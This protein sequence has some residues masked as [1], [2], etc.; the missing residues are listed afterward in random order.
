ME[1]VSFETGR[2][3][4]L[5]PTEEFIPLGGTDGMRIIRN[6]AERYEFRN[7]PE[8]PTRED[9]DKNGL[10]F[11]TGVFEFESKRSVIGEFAMYTDG[12]VAVSTTTEQ[13]GAFLDDLFEY[14]VSEFN[15]RR[16]ISPIKK[17]CVSVLTVEF[18][19]SIA[20]MLAKHAALIELVAQYLNAPLGTSHQVET[21]RMDFVLDD[22]TPVSNARPKFLIEA[23]AGVPLSRRRYYSSAA[24][25]TRHHL[26]LLRQIEETYLKSPA[27]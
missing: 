18:E 15:F 5:F 6:V 25:H 1:I 20:N 24:I 14:L 13:A 7:A 10:R 16:P 3:T 23:R 19:K 21:M 9:I 12:L 4:W 26:E 27:S 2:V 22:G 8:N 17:V 11:A